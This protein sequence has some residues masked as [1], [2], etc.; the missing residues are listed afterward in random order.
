[1]IKNI[2][3]NETET[4]WVLVQ[5]LWVLVQYWNL[6]KS[7]TQ[8]FSVAPGAGHHG[9]GRGDSGRRGGCRDRRGGSAPGSDRRRGSARG[10][11]GGQD[12]IA[13]T[14]RENEA[15]E[16]HPKKKDH[17]R[18][19]S[20]S[21]LEFSRNMLVFFGGVIHDN[22]ITGTW[23]IGKIWNSLRCCL[24]PGAHTWAWASTRAC[25]AGPPHH[26]CKLP[27]NLAK[28]K[29]QPPKQKRSRWKST[30]KWCCA[31]HQL[32]K[33]Q[34]Q[35]LAEKNTFGQYKSWKS[36]LEVTNISSIKEKNEYPTRKKEGAKLIFPAGY[37]PSCLFLGSC[38]A[39]AGGHH[40][41]CPRR[42]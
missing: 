7:T 37:K 32:H 20:T 27:M 38:C 10:L 22:S 15:M 2:N 28:V 39:F 4:L 5:L 9:P 21:K 19:E 12:V 35:E 3:K 40:G 26:L 13:I 42:F 16:N 18:S 34:E 25:W 24:T 17:F 30:D 33:W 1:M 11:L 6:W 29:E 14:P 36:T 41:Q 8:H 31:T 23:D